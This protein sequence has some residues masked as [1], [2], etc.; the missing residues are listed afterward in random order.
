M[1]V[2]TG[3]YADMARN[4]SGRSLRS[5]GGLRSSESHQRGAVTVERVL[6]F[7]KKV[8][9]VVSLPTSIVL[10]LGSRRINSAYRMTWWRRF[11]LGL[12]MFRTTLRLPS[13]SSYK[14][15]LAMALKLLELPPE[16]LGDVVECGSWKGASTANL[17]LVCRIVGRK[18]MVFDSFRGLP[19]GSPDDREAVNYRAG[20]YCGSL[21]EVRRN[22]RRYGSLQCCEFVEGWFKDTLY[23]IKAPV[24]LAFL[25][26]DLEESLDECVRN[27]WPNLIENGYLFTDE[28]V[29]TNYAALFY[30]E[31]WWRENFACAPPGLIGA[32][33]GLSVG[34]YYLGPWS[35][36]EDHPGQHA[37]PVAY[38]QKGMSGYWSFYPSG[39]RRSA[40]IEGAQP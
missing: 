36:V 19:V 28:C 6:S 13:G 38:T 32:G 34:E 18:L 29:N 9:Y 4:L 12:R 37:C 16:I 25:D 2:S 20:D 35:E 7:L 8:H 22:V 15:H 10:I 11:S 17:S 33:G 31:R 1:P 14:A 3:S 26:V 39:D 24:A 30:S 21:D 5:A 23:K 40:P 27:I